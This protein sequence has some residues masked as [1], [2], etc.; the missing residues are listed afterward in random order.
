MNDTT[1]SFHTGLSF[2]PLCLDVADL[3]RASAFY[4]GV[5]G[6]D[7]LAATSDETLLGAGGEPLIT[8]R[9][10]PDA[11]VPPPRA[12]G[13]FHVA[14]LVPTRTDLSAALRRLVGAGVPVGSADHRVSEAIYIS[15]PEGNGI[16]I[17]RDRPA[18]EWP[19]R[20]D[21]R[22]RIAT[23]A[24]DPDILGV[25]TREAGLPPGTIIG[26][27]HLKMNDLDEAVGF[28]RHALGLDVIARL[29]GATFLG[30]D[31]YH[32][33]VGLNT[34]QSAGGDP[35]PAGARGLAGLTARRAGGA[36]A[37]LVDPAGLPLQ[38]SP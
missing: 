37:D 11:G 20:A 3:P 28:Y 38:I 6:L 13:L 35:P 26:H 31:G 17:Y 29:P 1:R 27:V 18:D 10:R 34:W 21:G 33:H 36:H 4:T 22:P 12:A 19:R 15:D 16:E 23:L 2:G 9:A 25:A 7:V 5:L 8:L 24:L 32:H 30:A 14:F